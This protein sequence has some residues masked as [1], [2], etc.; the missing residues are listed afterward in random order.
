MQTD[1]NREIRG[2]CIT[3]AG[4]CVSPHGWFPRQVVVEV[5]AAFTVDTVGVVFTHTL[6]VHLNMK[7]GRLFSKHLLT[8]DEMKMSG[9]S[10]QK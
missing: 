4:V 8:I 6:S 10:Q 1:T 5:L 7:D 9:A 3:P 2:R